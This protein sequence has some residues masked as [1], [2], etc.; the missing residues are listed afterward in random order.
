[1]GGKKGN[2]SRGIVQFQLKP[3]FDSSFECTVPAHVLPRITSSLPSASLTFSSWPHLRELLVADPEYFQS[4]Q[5]DLLLGAEVYCQILQE[6]IV[7]GPLGSP[8]AQCTELGWIISGPTHPGASTG[9]SFSFHVSIDEDLYRLMHKFWE[10]DSVPSTDTVLSADEQLCEEHFLSTHSRNKE[11]RYVV[12]LPFKKSA[13]LLGDSRPRAARIMLRLSHKLSVDST[14]A[15][16]YTE[17]LTEYEQLDHMRLVPS[18]LPEP[19]QVYYLPHHGVKREHSLTTKLR[20]V[21]NGSSPSSSGLSLNDL[22]HTGAKLQIDLFDVLIW[23]RHFRYVFSSDME[24]MYRQIDVHPHDWN[25]QRILWCDQSHNLRAY[26]L[27]TVTYGLACAPFLALRTIQQLLN[28]EGSKYPLA[29]P[30]LRKGRYVDDLFGGADT[31][32]EAQAV[33]SQLTQLC[34][35]GGFKLKKWSSNHSEILTSIPKDEQIPYLTIG[36]D[37]DTIVHTL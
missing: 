35:A 30:S 28:D 11:G 27:T 7:K 4:R 3:H 15:G 25:F 26:Q 19:Q 31:V 16:L 33:V 23:F 37:D 36:S 24:K 10:I 32:E 14:Y 18:Q 22:L 1:V 9:S 29:A 20:V 5:I 8:M 2:N 17:F 34:M 12:R 6:G 21:F 13:H